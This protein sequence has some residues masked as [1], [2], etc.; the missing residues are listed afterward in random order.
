MEILQFLF[1]SSF[2]FSSTLLLFLNLKLYS[3]AEA[4]PDENPSDT[5]TLSLNQL[6]PEIL[7]CVGDYLDNP[8]TTLGWLNSHCRN[9]MSTFPLKR[10]IHDR[11][12]IPEMVTEDVA[13]DEPEL[14][15]LLFSLLKF[16]ADPNHVYQAL[17]NEFFNETSFFNLLPN[18]M[19]VTKR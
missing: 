11:F 17:K 19:N 15:P 7:H 3:C 8:Y 14:M 6:S 2:P 9:A 16:S 12:N 13:S 1:S 18:L 5:A 4:S 10:F